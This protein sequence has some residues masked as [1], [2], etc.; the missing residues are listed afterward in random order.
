[1]VP[2]RTHHGAAHLARSSI[3]RIRLFQG[4][5]QGSI[6][7]RATK[8]YKEEPVLIDEF[9]LVEDCLYCFHGAVFDRYTDEYKKCDWC[10]GTGKR[11]TEL[12]ILILKFVKD[13]SEY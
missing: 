4:L 9:V 12:G 2:V 8:T 1:V 10:L 6:P 3:G 11:P 13:Y 5:E 7:W